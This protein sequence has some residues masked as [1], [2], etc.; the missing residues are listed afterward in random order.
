M[1]DVK[2]IAQDPEMVK[3]RLKTRVTKE[4]DKQKIEDDIDGIC[5]LYHEIK[6]T[7]KA[8][9]DAKHLQKLLQQ[10]MME[11]AKPKNKK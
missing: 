11:M 8:L 1:L 6:L 9:D 7:R 3:E 4:E 10:D 5:L 2:M